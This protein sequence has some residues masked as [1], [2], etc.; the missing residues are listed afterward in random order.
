[1]EAFEK[2][3]K[4]YE[5]IKN[6]KYLKDKVIQ[7]KDQ[8]IGEKNDRILIFEEAICDLSIFYKNINP[9]I[10]LSF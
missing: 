1:M 4:V 10:E 6:D 3:L 9:K 2:E 7:V 5:L 8:I